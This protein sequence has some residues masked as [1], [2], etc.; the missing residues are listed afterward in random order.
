VARQTDARFLNDNI[1][2]TATTIATTA[3]KRRIDPK[4]TLEFGAITDQPHDAKPQA[5]PTSARKSLDRSFDSRV[6]AL[7]V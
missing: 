3:T 2:R 4:I 7:A 1:L 6:E 5:K